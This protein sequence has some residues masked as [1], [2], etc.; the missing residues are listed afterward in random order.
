MKQTAGFLILFLFLITA[1]FAP[2]ISPYNPAEQ[3]LKEQLKKPSFSNIFG[4]DKLGRDI[5]S[6]VIYGSRV[7]LSIGLTVL[8]ISLVIGMFIG[9]LAGYFGKVFDLLIMRIV[10][11]LQA[12]PGILLAIAFTA[13]SGPGFYKVIVALSL[14]G[15][16]GFARLFRGQVLSC[17]EQTYVLAARVVG[18]SDF[19]IIAK[20]ILPNIISPIIVEATFFIANMIL[21][22]AA[23]SFLGLGT[24]PPAPS[25]G[26]MLSEGKNYLLTAPHISIFPGAAIM[27]IVLALNFAGDYLRDKICETQDRSYL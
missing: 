18:A 2:F 21:A 7:S 3:N 17:R 12:F 20:H 5:A 19:K 26:A 10:D 4:R 15:W 25:W 11:V 23:L 13:V 8:F 9:I 1:V 6:R 14:T 24:Q 16:I 27:L 22:E